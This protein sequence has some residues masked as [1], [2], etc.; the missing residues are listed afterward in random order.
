[1]SANKGRGAEMDSRPPADWRD[2][3]VKKADTVIAFMLLAFCGFYAFLTAKLPD[4]NLPNTLGSAFMPWVLTASLLL[5][6]ILLLLK[7]LFG[8]VNA[9]GPAKASR[10]E[11]WGIVLPAAVI[12]GYIQAID[13]LGFLWAT[14]VFVAILMLISGSRKWTELLLVSILT[15]VGIY[16][17]FQEIFRVQLPAGTIF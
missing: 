4:R 3:A 2:G 6:S 12:L 10:E 8:S 13:L 11:G 9:K 15:T 1:M 5:L 17:F 16:L 14:P 7:A